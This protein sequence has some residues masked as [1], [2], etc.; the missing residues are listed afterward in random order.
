M[1]LPPRSQAQPGRFRRSLS[2]FGLSG[3]RSLLGA[4]R[5][6]R[7]VPQ[8]GTPGGRASRPVARVPA[9]VAG[10]QSSAFPT[11]Q[12]EASSPTSPSRKEL[13]AARPSHHGCQLR[14]PGPGARS[15]SPRREALRAAAP[16]GR[17][18]WGRRRTQSPSPQPS[19]QASV[20]PALPR[21][22]R[23]RSTRRPGPRIVAASVGAT[24]ATA[25]GARRTS[26]WRCPW[27]PTRRGCCLARRGAPPR[28][29]GPTDGAQ[30]RSRWRPP[31]R[32]PCLHRSQERQRDCTARGP[33]K[34]SAP[35][36]LE[37]PRAQRRPRRRR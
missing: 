34:A 11:S 16:L 26:T 21:R 6:Q 30:R 36:W 12:L 17:W 25:A 18:R 22:P 13:P 14:H 15:D 33:A 5:P 19:P 1:Q 3:G 8:G 27:P 9:R 29:G 4:W 28:N 32:P 10:A 37:P 24:I 35:R 31:V 2:D 7:L 23:A 20:G